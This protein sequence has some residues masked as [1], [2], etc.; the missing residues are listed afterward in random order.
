M[1][2]LA[3]CGDRSPFLDN[4][5]VADRYAARGAL[6]RADIR[7]GQFT[8]RSYRNFAQPASGTL[9]VY[10]E[11]DGSGWLAG[12]QQPDPTPDNPT[13]L[14]LAAADSSPNR[15]YLAR[16][17]QYEIAPVPARCNPSY[18]STRRYA[19]EVIA[20]MSLA[21]DQAARPL[22][23]PRIRL[24]GFSGG[25][26][27]SALV[28]A[29]RTDVTQLVTVAGNLDHG[30]WTRMFKVTP[31]AGSLNP[32]DFA[33]TLARIPQVHFSGMRDDIVPKAVL[34][35]YLRRLPAG[36]PVRVVDV[37]RADHDC[38]WRDLWPGLLRSHLAE[39]F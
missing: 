22:G 11:G 33:A 7:A 5:Q 36:S 3:G 6:Q 24:V 13:A 29:R 19:E 23:A 38:C 34:E 8:L 9:T 25:G 18:W 26:P 1:V 31:L 20:A 35:A 32:P 15:L 30:E 14:A 17:C 4:D 21:I 39:P 27:T 16:P 2:S 12:V 28:A 10:I 37:P